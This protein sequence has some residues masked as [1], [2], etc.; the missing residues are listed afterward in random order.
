MHEHE[1]RPA[2][3]LTLQH[4]DAHLVSRALQ[5]HAADLRDR[6]DRARPYAAGY[7]ALAA[8]AELLVDSLT[9]TM[10]ATR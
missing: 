3:V 2:A 6:A 7:L 9:I 8:R 10:E 1:R 4:T 5:L